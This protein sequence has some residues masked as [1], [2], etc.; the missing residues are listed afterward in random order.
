M[1]IRGYVEKF[2]QRY[3]ERG[4]K[5]PYK[6][7]GIDWLPLGGTILFMDRN[8]STLHGKYGSR[9]AQDALGKALVLGGWTVASTIVVFKGI[10]SLV[11]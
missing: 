5:E 4:R 2:L 8:E 9:R 10:E 6:W 11:N 7:Q 1:N 3:N